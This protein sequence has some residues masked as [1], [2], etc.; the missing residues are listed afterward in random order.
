MMK[1]KLNSGKIRS[2]ILTIFSPITAALRLAPEFRS[3]IS[4]K[5]E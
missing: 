2:K 1:P 3:F 4:M 5:S